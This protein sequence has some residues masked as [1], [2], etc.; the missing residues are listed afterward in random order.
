MHLATEQ[1]K[2]CKISGLQ[3]LYLSLSA[4]FGLFPFRLIHLNK[5][6]NILLITVS[7]EEKPEQYHE[8][9]FVFHRFLHRQS[10]Q[11]L[12]AIQHL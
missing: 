3:A 11:C 6:T 5:Q 7:G 10:K 1:E 4:M 9:H 2:G 8:E 12:V